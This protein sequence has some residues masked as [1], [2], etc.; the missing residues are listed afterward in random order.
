MRG[1]YRVLLGMYTGAYS[2]DLNLKQD[3]MVI[4]QILVHYNLI[5]KNSVFGSQTTTATDCS[6]NQNF[7]HM[8]NI[9]LDSDQTFEIEK[10][11][12]QYQMNG[13]EMN[14]ILPLPDHGILRFDLVEVEGPDPKI[15]TLNTHEFLNFINRLKLGKLEC[16]NWSYCL[17]H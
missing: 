12:L 10:Y 16:R 13:S 17:R 9:S 4:E 5:V 15:A 14:E 3:Q 1:H 2:I 8:S 11:L 6:Q 7:I